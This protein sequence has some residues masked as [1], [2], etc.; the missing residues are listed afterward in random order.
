M[1]VETLDPDQDLDGRYRLR[2]QPAGAAHLTGAVGEA[3]K[4]LCARRRGRAIGRSAERTSGLLLYV[5]Y[6]SIKADPSAVTK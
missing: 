4:H 2:N 5:G 3:E 1:M 6:A